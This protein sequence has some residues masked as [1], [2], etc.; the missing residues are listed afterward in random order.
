MGRPFGE[1]FGQ[2]VDGG[3]LGLM[4]IP[5]VLYQVAVS[6]RDAGR[7]VHFNLLNQCQV[8]AHVD[9]RVVVTGLREYVFVEIGVSVVEY[10]MVL[11]V[12]RRD[13]NDQLFERAERL[14]VSKLLPRVEE[15]ATHL[16]SITG[17]HGGIVVEFCQ[18][19][20][21]P[22][23]VQWKCRWLPVSSGFIWPWP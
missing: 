10:R 9:K 13:L 11:R 19:P 20:N 14:L 18:R 21:N 3:V 4:F 8:Q 5:Q 2:T 12:P 17:E 23:P 6:E 1:P 16:F 22:T 7:P 15:N